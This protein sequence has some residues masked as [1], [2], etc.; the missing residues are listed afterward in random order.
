[1]REGSDGIHVILQ[2]GFSVLGPRIEYL[3]NTKQECYPRN[4]KTWF[5]NLLCS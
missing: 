3:W 2:S 1:V 5:A 4:N